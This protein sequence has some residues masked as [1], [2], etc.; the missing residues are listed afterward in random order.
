MSARRVARVVPQR[1]V[2]LDDSVMEL[3]YGYIKN[4]RTRT[5]QKLNGIPFKKRHIYVVKP[6]VCSSCPSL[7]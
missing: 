1:G 6:D 7:Y 3:K 4:H 5:L 2:C